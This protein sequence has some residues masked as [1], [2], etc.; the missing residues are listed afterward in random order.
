MTEAGAH[1][2]LV[3]L[4]R[5]DDDVVP[6]ADRGKLLELRALPDTPDGI[7]W[8]AQDEEFDVVVDD[9]LREVL[10]VDLVVSLYEPQR[11]V[12][13]SA[14]VLMN[15]VRERV[16][17]GLLNEYGI[18]R[19]CKRTDGICNGKDHTGGDDEVTSLYRPV[20][21]RL[22]PVLKNGEVVVLYLRI[23]EDTVIGAL[24]ERCDDG[25]GGAKVHVCDPERQNVRRVT[26]FGSKVILQTGGIPAVDDFVKVDWHIGYPFVMR[27]LYS[28][29][30]E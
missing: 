21:S 17:D 29:S 8:A 20:M 2:L 10:E 7:V 16:V 14:F 1:E 25:G 28:Y 11:I 3:N 27:R 26:A 19:S 30:L 18:A 15:H 23:A 5:D 9:F 4:V 22:K 12:E 24:L 13:K 6:Q